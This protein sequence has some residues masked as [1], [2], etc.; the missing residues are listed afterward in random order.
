MD[1]GRGVFDESEQN[2]S[3]TK[4]FRKAYWFGV[5]GLFGLLGLS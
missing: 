5:R 1:I 2:I 4:W 3:L